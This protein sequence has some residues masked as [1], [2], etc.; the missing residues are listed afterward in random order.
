[1]TMTLNHCC[2][3]YNATH[4]ARY[5]WP[6]MAESFVL[7]TGATN[8]SVGLG[9]WQITPEAVGNVISAAVNVLDCSHSLLNFLSFQQKVECLLLVI[10]SLLASVWLT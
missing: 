7:N 6:R 3:N 5:H 1:M 8:P 9:V 10:A 2:L 4:P